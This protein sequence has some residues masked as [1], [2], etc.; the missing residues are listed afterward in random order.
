[1]CRNCFK[2]LFKLSAFNYFP[3]IIDGKKLDIFCLSNW[4]KA[5]NKRFCLSFF[6]S[7]FS[8][9]RRWPSFWS[10]L[11]NTCC[12]KKSFIPKIIL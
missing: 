6:Y 1:M 8:P 9:R 4:N 2:I 12:L 7:N 11:S 5:L 3:M 10:T